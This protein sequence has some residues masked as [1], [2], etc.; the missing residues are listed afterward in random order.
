MTDGTDSNKREKGDP[1][2]SRQVQGYHGR[3]TIRKIDT[4]INVSFKRGNVAANQP[5]VHLSKLQA[6]KVNG[7]ADPKADYSYSTRSME[8][9]R[10]GIELYSIRCDNCD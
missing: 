7:V 9:Q 10:D 3:A 6:G 2:P 8:D 1:K 4:G 5:L